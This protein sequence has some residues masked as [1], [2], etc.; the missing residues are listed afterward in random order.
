MGVDTVDCKRKAASVEEA[1]GDANALKGP[2]QRNP[3]GISRRLDI[4]VVYPVAGD[5]QAG[6]GDF[7][8]VSRRGGVAKRK[9]WS[10]TACACSA[11]MRSGVTG[12]GTMM[13]RRLGSASI[14]VIGPLYRFHS[15]FQPC[16]SERATPTMPQICQATR[17]LYDGSFQLISTRTKFSGL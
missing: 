7:V 4:G 17:T 14:F 12:G 3:A 6:N 5:K 11:A 13:S 2:D 8:Y 16:F 15:H 1:L 9:P 10:H